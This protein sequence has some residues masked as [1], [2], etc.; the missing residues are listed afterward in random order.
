[1]L[2]GLF[3]VSIMSSNNNCESVIRCVLGDSRPDLYNNC[4]SQRRTQ[5]FFAGAAWLAD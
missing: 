4:T 1:M 2:R 3:C 5:Q